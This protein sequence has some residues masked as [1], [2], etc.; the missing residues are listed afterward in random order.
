MYREERMK[1]APTENHYSKC[2]LKVM[3]HQSGTV[4]SVFEAKITIVAPHFARM[5]SSFLFFSSSFCLTTLAD[6]RLFY[7]LLGFYFSFSFLFNIDFEA[8]EERERE[9][10][11]QIRKFRQYMV[12]MVGTES[13]FCDVQIRCF[14]LFSASRATRAIDTHRRDAVTQL[15]LFSNRI[16]LCDCFFFCVFNLFLGAFDPHWPIWRKFHS[17]THEMCDSMSDETIETARMGTRYIVDTELVP[18]IF[19]T[20]CFCFS[21]LFSSARNAYAVCKYEKLKCD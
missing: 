17:H 18:G 19:F 10:K 5:T 21:F 9:E 16:W 4:E 20:F 2:S 8:R 13:G 15:Y 14:C 11:D 12:V 7:D 3:S 6:W 1:N